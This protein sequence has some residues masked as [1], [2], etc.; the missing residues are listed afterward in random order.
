MALKDYIL[1]YNK[2]IKDANVQPD[3]ILNELDISILCV[4]LSA[5]K[6]I[7]HRTIKRSLTDQVYEPKFA[8]S[9]DRLLSLSYIVR[10]EYRHATF[11]TITLEGKQTLT[12]LEDR[13]KALLSA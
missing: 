1:G 2:V 10:T 4:L 3:T 11:Y 9:L 8:R 12:N 7:R 13:F 6:G 5:N